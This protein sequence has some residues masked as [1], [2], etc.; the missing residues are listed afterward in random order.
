MIEAIHEKSVPEPNTGCLIFV[1][2][3]QSRGYGILKKKLVHRVAFEAAGG[4]IPEGMTIDHLCGVKC[5]VNPEHM[6]VVTR[7]ENTRRAHEGVFSDFC[8]R[9]HDMNDPANI[10]FS[11]K[12]DGRIVRGCKGCADFH[13]SKHSKKGV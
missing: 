7:C 1:G 12:Q 4:V 3:W 10:Y 5:C 2:P 8:K 11:K 13:N 9:G 6:E